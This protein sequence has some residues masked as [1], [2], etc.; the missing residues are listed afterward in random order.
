[1]SQEA[2]QGL[3][4]WSRLNAMSVPPGDQAGELSPSPTVGCVSGEYMVPEGAWAQ[5]LPR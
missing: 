1:M 2:S 3:A 4:V 5:M